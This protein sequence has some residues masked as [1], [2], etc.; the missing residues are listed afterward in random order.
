MVSDDEDED[1]V[2]ETKKRK[3]KKSV[4]KKNVTLFYKHSSKIKLNL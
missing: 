4:G 3:G 1:F 2:L